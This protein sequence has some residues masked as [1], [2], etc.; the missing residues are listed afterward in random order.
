MKLTP[1]GID[2]SPLGSDIAEV[3]LARAALESA[4]I[5]AII[6]RGLMETAYETLDKY[7]TEME[8]AAAASGWATVDTCDSQF[9]TALV[10]AAGSPRCSECSPPSSSRRCGPVP[11]WSPPDVLG[12]TPSLE[13]ASSPMPSPRA[14]QIRLCR[15]QPGNSDD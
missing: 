3:C 1:H 6:V 10:A 14:T 13:T 7:V 11:A 15:Q 9:H 8:A 4:A 2:T 5:R 12:R